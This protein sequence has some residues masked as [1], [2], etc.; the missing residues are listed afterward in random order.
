MK[1]RVSTS[2]KDIERRKKE[3]HS[4]LVKHLQDFV[5]VVEGVN[6]SRS[7]LFGLRDIEREIERDLL[8]LCFDHTVT[9]L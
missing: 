6:S 7:T 4:I 2:S 5:D 9:L 8:S 1:P 3:T